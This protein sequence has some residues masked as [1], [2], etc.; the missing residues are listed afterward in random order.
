VVVAVVSIKMATGTS[1]QTGVGTRVGTA[2]K[3]TGL[4]SFTA[5]VV[6]LRA[7]PFRT[8]LTTAG[9]L[10]HLARRTADEREAERAIAAR[11][12]AMRWF[13]GR[14]ACLE[15][16]L[17]AFIFVTLHGRGVDWCI[18]CRFLPAESHA[19][20]QI[21]SRPVGEPDLPDRPFH[22]TVHV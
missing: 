19:W 9:L 17:A 6:L 3:L 15:N 5:A 14:A 1:H 22:V 12:W 4:A 16:S 10:K 20:I 8:V 21:N 11:D 13:P 7:L 18:G 2:D